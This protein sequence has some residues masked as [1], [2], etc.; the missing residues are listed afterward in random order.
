MRTA[1]PVP[2]SS[3]QTVTVGPGV[4]PGQRTHQGVSGRGLYRQWGISPRP[5]DI[6]FSC[7]R[8]IICQGKKK[9]KSKFQN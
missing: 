9:D 3:I 6:G 8:R 1:L 4:S 7:P 5:E 2:S